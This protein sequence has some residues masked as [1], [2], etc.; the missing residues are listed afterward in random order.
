VAQ[1]LDYATSIVQMS[2]ER[3]EKAALSGISSPLQN[4]NALYE[5]LP[6]GD[7]LS[8]A[9][10]VDAVNHNL[11]RGRVLLLVVGDG[12]RREAETLLDGLHAYARFGFTLA[13]VELGVFRMPE[14]DSHLIR[15]RTLAKTEIIQRTV[16]EIAGTGASVKEAKPSVPATLG[17]ASYWDAIEAKVPG[18][19]DALNALIKAVELLGVYPELLAS[20]NLKWQ[21][22]GSKPVN[23]GYIHKNG[24]IWTDAA[25]WFAP[26]DLTRAYVEDVA[27][28]FGCEAKAFSA[29]GNLS[30]YAD[31]TPL[32]L[33]KVLDRLDAWIA[34]PQRFITAIQAYDSKIDAN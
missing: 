26:A 5:A 23:L 31:G 13:L 21:R 12:I 27:R 29:S 11:R 28:A 4:P 7:K 17:S 10:F 2:Y 33:T 32:R 22:P 1:V 24:A 30:L 18:S 19:R 9:A 8:H 20:L 16:V 25:S 34:P 6:E 14:Q 15:P 3:F